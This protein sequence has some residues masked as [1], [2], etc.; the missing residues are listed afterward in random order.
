MFICDNKRGVE[1]IMFAGISVDTSSPVD[2]GKKTLKS[3]QL[4]NYTDCL[5][6]TLY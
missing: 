2:L 1:M 3:L 4:L 6:K 5:T